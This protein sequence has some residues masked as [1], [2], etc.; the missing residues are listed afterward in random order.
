MQQRGFRYSSQLP[1]FTIQR[2]NII[3]YTMWDDRHSEEHTRMVQ[4]SWKR[5]NGIKSS[6][7]P[8]SAKPLQNKMRA[9]KNTHRALEDKNKEKKHSRQK[10]RTEEI[11]K[12]KQ[13]ENTSHEGVITNEEKNTSWMGERGERESIDNKI[14]DEKVI[15]WGKSFENYVSFLVWNNPCSKYTQR[16]RYV[17]VHACQWITHQ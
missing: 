12:T 10:T 1:G 7:T 6:T 2:R 3:N 11:W 4:H 16:M 15:K 17:Y 9:H 13:C 5:N 8:S 14:S